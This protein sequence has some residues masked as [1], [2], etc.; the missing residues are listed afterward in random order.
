MSSRLQITYVVEPDPAALA[1]HA[2][3]HL[4]ELAEEAVSARGRV[5]IAFSGGSTPKATF[6]LLADPSHPFLHSMPWQ[7]LELFFVDERT[8]PPDDAESNFRMTKEAL[9][10]H[11]NLRPE[12]IHRMQGELEPEVAAAE[13]E[14]DLRRTFRL[15][16]AEAPRFD[17]VT[18]GMGPDGHTA[19]LFPHTE[20]IHEMGRLVVANQVPQKNT[21]R[22]T[23]TWPVINH[24][25]EVFFLIA[26]ADKAEP[27]K[28]V[29]MGPKDVE[30]LPSQLI[31]PASGILTL[32]L[33][34][35]AAALLPPPGADG[36]GHL[37]RAR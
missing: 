18:L 12:Q 2:A 13:Y 26:G 35:A 31:W 32:I 36:K 17:I 16:G 3:K 24:A 10:D 23:L 7:Q 25:R 19:S 21:W 20:A 8:V 5:R 15:E 34:K 27:L 9:L 1:W 6:A 37:E 30:R 29:L 11:V 33:D 28:E 14:Y 4:V 22:V